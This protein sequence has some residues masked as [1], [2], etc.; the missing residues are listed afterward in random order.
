MTTL[1]FSGSLE[2]QLDSVR[3]RV[4]EIFSRMVR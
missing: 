2:D 4:R 3:L 1:E